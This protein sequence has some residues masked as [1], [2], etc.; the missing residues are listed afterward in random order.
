MFS[1]LGGLFNAIVN[2]YYYFMIISI[3]TEYQNNLNKTRK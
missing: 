3:K 1:P 2:Q